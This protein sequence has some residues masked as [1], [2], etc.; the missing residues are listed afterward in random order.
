[1]KFNSKGEACGGVG[2]GI[3]NVILAT[4]PKI[5]VGN[6]LPDGR[7][8]VGGAACW[9]DDDHVIYAT[10]DYDTDS[11]P[12][13]EKCNVRTGKKTKLVDRGCNKMVAG[14]GKFAAFLAD[15]GVFGDFRAATGTV[16]D[17]DR[18]GTIA[19]TANYAD[20]TGT[21][22]YTV[23]G[24]VTPL[25]EAV[26][27]YD[28][29]VT[30][31]TSAVW[32]DLET[33]ALNALNQRVPVQCDRVLAPKIVT[34]DGEDWIVYWCEKFGL[35]THPVEV[36]KGYIIRSV[37]S[38][39]GEN[40][41]YNHDAC[42]FNGKLRVGY[43]RRQGEYPEDL[44][45]FDQDLSLPRVDFGAATATPGGHPSLPPEAPQGVGFTAQ[46][47]GGSSTANS[48]VLVQPQL[49]LLE[50]DI[51]YRLSLLAV[52]VLQ[53]I[54]D[55]YPGVV[56]KS[57]FRQANSGIS[58]HELGE[59]VDLQINNQTPELLYEVA[60]Y[61]KNNLAFD[62]MVLNFTTMGDGQPWIHISFSPKSLR[63]Q[64]LTKDFA[65]TFHEG[66][67]FVEPLTGE[68]L[69]AAEREAAALDADIFKEMQATAKRQAKMF[70]VSTVADEVQQITTGTTARAA[71]GVTGSGSGGTGTGGA[72]NS[73]RAKLVACVQSALNLK[74]TPFVSQENVELAFEIVKRVAWLLKDE[75][76][77]LL[78]GP[79]G[80]ENIVQWNGYYFR[81]GRICYPDG[82]IYKVLT[83]VEDGPELG[84]HDPSW[85]DDGLVET[86]LYVP[87][88]DPGED[89]NMNWMACPLP[90]PDP[91]TEST[92]TLPK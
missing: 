9:F 36:L 63:Y 69:A 23:D 17:A 10:Y 60:N 46:T 40:A 16:N 45:I 34:V 66:L 58:Q 81:A 12:I 79:P 51:V 56:I 5:I 91:S 86:S 61:I 4:G 15:F 49:G 50:D 43:S 78:I 44:V 31:P 48:S 77:G 82:Q 90:P 42:E 25:P 71:S 83:G 14:G 65:D 72:N 19:I 2:D 39:S 13:I 74:G 21:V 41:A 6:P 87:A 29:Q 28:L 33:G 24:R 53:P 75:G 57:G 18:E 20:G 32:V 30:G 8:A 54:K 27:A 76:A 59:A 92:D 68:E 3:V 7:T 67:F 84:F 85:S 35:I 70:P 73:Q 11:H 88:M 80:G 64:V 89:I 22:L 55:K 26:Q 37:A 47:G 1:M 62:Q 38:I 52:N